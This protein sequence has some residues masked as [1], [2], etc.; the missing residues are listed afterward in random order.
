MAIGSTGAHGIGRGKC[1]VTVAMAFALICSD[2]AAALRSSTVTV[3]LKVLTRC[4]VLAS[5][6]LT[7]C[8]NWL[9]LAGAVVSTARFTLPLGLYS[10]SG[11]V[12]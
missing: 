9:D 3:L 1:G 7:S 5:T 2:S 10:G 11:S 4:S 8:S 6:V 12:G